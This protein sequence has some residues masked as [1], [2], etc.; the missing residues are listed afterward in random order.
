ML[1]IAARGHQGELRTVRQIA[2]LIGEKL[3][4]APTSLFYLVAWKAARAWYGMDAIR[5]EEVY[6]LL[7]QLVYLPLAAAGTRL[8][9][10]EM[11]AGR[12]WAVVVITIVAYFWCMT[13]AVLSIVRYMTPAMGLLFPAVAIALERCTKRWR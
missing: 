11:P 13:T 8:I 9:W 3:H 10:R 5:Y 6:G 2:G 7:A 1:D 4:D 12:T